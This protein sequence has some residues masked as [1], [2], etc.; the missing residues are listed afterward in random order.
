MFPVI[1]PSARRYYGM[2]CENSKYACGVHLHHM[3]SDLN[4]AYVTVVK[5]EEK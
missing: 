5:T 3:I 2:K 4:M 1:V